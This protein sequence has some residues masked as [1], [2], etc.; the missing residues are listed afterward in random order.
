M[1]HGMSDPVKIAPKSQIIGEV[2]PAPPRA[3]RRI[4]DL[5]RG[6]LVEM[7]EKGKEKCHGSDEKNA[8]WQS[9]LDVSLKRS[10]SSPQ[11]ERGSSE[12]CHSA[13]NLTSKLSMS[14]CVHCCEMPCVQ[15]S[16]RSYARN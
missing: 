15:W 2:F 10:L 5:W 14:I 6:Q 9:S 11:S 13:K 12:D 4:F 16:K 3:E 7:N 8:E 1:I